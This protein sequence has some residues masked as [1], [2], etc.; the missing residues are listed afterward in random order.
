MKQSSTTAQEE[1]RFHGFTTGAR[2]RPIEGCYGEGSGGISQD[3]CVVTALRSDS[4][5]NKEGSAKN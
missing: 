5:S 3:L 2:M 1:V 4:R